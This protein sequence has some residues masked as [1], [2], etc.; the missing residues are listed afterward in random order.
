MSPDAGSI[1]AASTILGSRRTL[2]AFNERRRYRLIFLPLFFSCL[3]L[4]LVASRPVIQISTRDYEGY[5][6]VLLTLPSN[7]SCSLEKSDAFLQV[8]LRSR[9][10]FELRQE[11]FESRLVKSF[12]W[13]KGSDFFGLIIELRHGGFRYESFRVERR[14][15]LAIDFYETAF[16]VP[17]SKEEKAAAEP[18]RKENIPDVGEA[19]TE[20]AS[21]RGVSGGTKIRTIVIDPGHGGLEVGAKGKFGSLEKDITLAISLKLQSLIE[22][23]LG[24]Q[25]VLTRDRD[26]DVSLDNRAGVANNHHAEL[27]VSIHAN[28]SLRRNASG[29]E[30]Y[31]L[32]LNATDEEA[33]RLAY[34]ENTTAQLEKPL[35]NENKDDIMMI[36]WD[37]AQSAYLKQSQRLAEIIQEE[38]NTLL[39]TADRGIK[40]APFKVLTAVACPAVLVEV[41]FISNPDEEKKLT[42]EAFQEMI[43]Q[44]IFQGIARYV[45][46][47]S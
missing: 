9:T 25:A 3:V 39:G 40:Q 32:S 43:A 12:S 6:R 27:F 26:I 34:L 44:A 28:S 41:A 37:M 1:P 10:V 35:D 38:L 21:D 5:S 2:K 33:R 20:G 19:R 15:Q 42:T 29:S 7:L 30:T 18:P 23:N 17:P 46:L 11:P 36:L 4:I 45:K 24:F 14:N 22:R 8:R 47:I 31:F 16:E 13:V